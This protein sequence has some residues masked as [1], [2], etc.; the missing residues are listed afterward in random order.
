MRQ[1]VQRWIDFA[2][3]DLETARV[4][5]DAQKF[6]AAV[7][8]CQQMI[9]KALKGLYISEVD[10]MFPRTHSLAEIAQPTSFPRDQFDFLRQ[11]TSRYI[12]TRYPGFPTEKMTEIY[13]EEYAAEVLAKSE[14]I[15]E[16]IQNQLNR[17]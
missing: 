8:H 5:Y 15:L 12:D 16:W 11:L 4:L 7:F 1:E 2:I 9:E 3:S 10:A 14:G 17:I 13:D 6:P